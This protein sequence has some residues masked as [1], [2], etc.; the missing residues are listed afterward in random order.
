[1]GA[2][3]F[4]RLVMAGPFRWVVLTTGGQVTTF[5]FFVKVLYTE[6][7][8]GTVLF[9]QSDLQARGE[10]D[11]FA[12][13]SDNLEVAEYLR[14]RIFSYT[15]FAGVPD[16]SPPAPL[17]QAHF[18]GQDDFPESIV[19]EM[20]AVDGTTVKLTFLRLGTPRLGLRTVNEGLAEV[21]AFA[22]PE[23]FRLEI[24][25]LAPVGEL[26]RGPLDEA[27]PIGAD[28]QNVWYAKSP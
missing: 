15:P 28:L 3:E 16:Q 10:D 11:V 5:L 18:R 13:F 12:V 19:E 20:E 26:G 21:T 8:Q 27:P 25:G 23:D 1:M 22:L 2:I 14:D 6:K 4:K 17:V 7:G 9:V 24:N